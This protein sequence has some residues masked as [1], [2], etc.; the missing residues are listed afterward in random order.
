[1]EDFD[2]NGHA[3]L[4]NGHRL[5]PAR[6]PPRHLVAARAD[7]VRSHQPLRARR[8]DARGRRGGGGPGAW[9]EE[10]WGGGG[11]GLKD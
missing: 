4:T 6:R 8:Q 9:K 1:M 2:A 10:V 7:D 3:P 5:G 11:G